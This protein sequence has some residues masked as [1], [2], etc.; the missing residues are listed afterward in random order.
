M[1]VMMKKSVEYL[2]YKMPRYDFNVF[3]CVTTGC[4][5]HGT[6]VGIYTAVIIRLNALYTDG[7]S[8]WL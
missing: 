8:G 7:A 2:K 1:R 3:K 4:L 5:L 6:N